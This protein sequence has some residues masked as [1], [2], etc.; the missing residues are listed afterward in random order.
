[1]VDKQKEEKKKITGYTNYALQFNE[2]GRTGESIAEKRGST[3]QQS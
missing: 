3:K 1:M 2:I